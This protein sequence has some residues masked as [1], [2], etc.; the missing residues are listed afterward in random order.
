[1]NLG[2]RLRREPAIIGRDEIDRDLA[3]IPVDAHLRA[4]AKSSFE[5]AFHE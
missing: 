4:W 2:A 5:V 1:M 3:Q